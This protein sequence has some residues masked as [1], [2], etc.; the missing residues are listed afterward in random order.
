MT[1][2]YLLGMKRGASIDF[3]N[4]IISLFRKAAKQGFD[5]R[6][7]PLRGTFLKHVRQ[8]MGASA[9]TIPQSVMV[10][11]SGPWLPKFS[12]VEQIRDL[13]L[14]SEFQNVE[15]LVVNKDPAIRFHKYV[16]PEGEQLLEVNGGRWYAETYNKL[17]IDHTKDWLFP[18]IFYID[19]TGT[20]AMQRFPLEPFM[21]TTTILKRCVRER[22]SAWRHLGFI[23]HATMTLEEVRGEQC[24]YSISVYQ[25]C[26]RTL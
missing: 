17:G 19:K 24:N 20:D 23:P 1:E 8:H 9:P 7:A 16:V 2:F 4:E 11:Q 6:T 25:S 14:S 21:F 10:S 3:M 15:N 18:L 26:Y 12:L 22:A 5:M 13:L